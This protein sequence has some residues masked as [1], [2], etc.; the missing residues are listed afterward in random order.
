MRTIGLRATPSVLT[1][2]V[3]ESDDNSILNVEDI[4]IPLAFSMPDALKYIRNN[5]L[6]ILREYEISRAGIRIT[7]SNSQTLKIERIQI[8]GVLQEAF[9]S[10]NIQNYFVGQISSISARL[11]I[12]RADFKFYAEGMKA[13]EIDGWNM[14]TTVNQREALFCAVGASRA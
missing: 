2:V 10:S 6:D 1:F 4:K 11:G 13:W 14:L 3:Y 5:V 9:A 7:E 12:P 8:E